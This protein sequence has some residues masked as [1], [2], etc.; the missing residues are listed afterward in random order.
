VFR[1]GSL[2]PGEY[3]VAAYDPPDA[4][5][6]RM[7]EWQDTALLADL[8]SRAERI[9]LGARDVRQVTVRSGGR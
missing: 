7:S 4:A 6:F 9:V 3:F 5:A 1:V 2:P 8:A